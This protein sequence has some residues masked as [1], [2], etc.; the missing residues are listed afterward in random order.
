MDNNLYYV[1][2]FNNRKIDAIQITNTGVPDVIF[3]GVP[4]WVYEGIINNSTRK[5]F[6]TTSAVQVMRRNRVVYRQLSPQRS[7]RPCERSAH[8][9]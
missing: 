6:A 4:D 2:H 9:Q 8:A 1:P 7:V 3:N 5:V